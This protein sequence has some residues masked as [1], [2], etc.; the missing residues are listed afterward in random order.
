MAA[1]QDPIERQVLIPARPETVFKFLVEPE[2]MAR[3]IGR[4]QFAIADEVFGGYPWYHVPALLAAPTFP[5]A[6]RGSWEP[7]LQPD[8]AGE[9]GRRDKE[10]AAAHRRT[11]PLL[12][13]LDADPEHPAAAARIPGP[14][15]RAIG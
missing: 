3:W 1:E 15:D 7:L 8:V 4:R 2:L 6:A 12:L 11:F 13:I 9:G 5:W 10:G 14:V